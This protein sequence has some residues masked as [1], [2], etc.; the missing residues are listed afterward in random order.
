MLLGGIRARL[1]EQFW[2]NIR[3]HIRQWWR[4]LRWWNDSVH[5]EQPSFWSS[6]AHCDE[7]MA[8]D[9]DG[10]GALPGV[11]GAARDARSPRSVCYLNCAYDYNGS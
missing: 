2:Q 4:R 10:S 11:S 3:P 7:S 9:L 6:D 5:L 8:T 1:L